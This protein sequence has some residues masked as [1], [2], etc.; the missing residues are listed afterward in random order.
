[1]FVGR[2]DKPIT[3][4]AVAGAVKSRINLQISGRRAYGALWWEKGLFLFEFAADEGFDHRTQ[5]LM[6]NNFEHF[7]LHAFDNAGHEGFH[8]LGIGGGWV[9]SG[10]IGGNWMGG[11]AG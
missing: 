5:Y 11:G 7:G 4:R 10:W 1:M 2:S 8:E 3:I 6:G 9:G